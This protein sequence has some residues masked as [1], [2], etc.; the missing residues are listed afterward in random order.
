MEGFK[1]W[2]WWISLSPDLY[3]DYAAWY[4]SPL[5]PLETL[6]FL[7]SKEWVG[8]SFW[9]HLQGHMCDLFFILLM[10]NLYQYSV[11]GSLCD[12]SVELEL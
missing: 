1:K 4:W 8:V 3:V 2:L 11:T 12:F 5:D 6:I 9:K 7:T 10:E